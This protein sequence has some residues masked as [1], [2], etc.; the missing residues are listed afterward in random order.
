MLFAYPI[1][2]FALSALLI[3]I[4]V[5]LFQLRRYKKVV[6]SDIRFLKQITE[7]NQKQRNIKEWIILATRCLALACL[8]LAFAK[9]FIPFGKINI[10]KGS[11]KTISLF[12][13][14]S[15]SM[16]QQN[17]EGQLLEVAKN[18]AKEIASFYNDNDNFLL[19]SNDFE[20]KHQQ[21]LN[22]KDLLTLI[23]EVKISQQSKDLA[24][25]IARQ[26]QQLEGN[27]G[28]NKIAY[29]ISD[30]Q[31]NQFQ[32]S[33][34]TDSS[35]QFHLVQIKPNQNNNI[36]I[37][38]AW[39][40]QPIILPNTSTNLSVKV[41]NF[42]QLDISDV[43][44]TFKID[45]IQKGIA[46]ISCKANSSVV[47]QLQFTLNDIA[48]HQAELSVL[49]NPVVF[50]DKLLL[51][52]KAFGNQT[53][54]L[55]NANDYIQKVFTLDE[56][57]KIINQSEKAIDYSLFSNASLIIINEMST[58]SSGF[59]TEIQK[60]LT[61]GGIVLFIPS[62]Q[63]NNQAQINA[64]LQ[65]INAPLYGAKTAQR[66]SV[67]RINT[68][69]DV[70]KNVF[71]KIPE[72][73][74][75]PS[76]NTFYPLQTNSS[77]NG[78]AV[79]TLNNDAPFIFKSKYGKGYTYLLSV[80]L[81]KEWSNFTEHALFVP[82][83]LRL[84]LVNKQSNQ[85]YYYTTKPIN[86]IFDKNISQKVIYLKKDKQEMAFDLSTR[87]NR[88]SITID[89]VKQAGNYLLLNQSKTET[90]AAISFNVNRKESNLALTSINEQTTIPLLQTNELLKHQKEIDLTYNGTQLW[91]WFLLAA[92]A[93]I[94]VEVVLLKLK[95]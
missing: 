60:Y 28:L 82:F 76:V 75:W 80:P 7:Q 35:V 31:A 4:I 79:A 63:N 72:L 44:L 29:I 64:F 65:Q 1:F 71:S 73:S 34:S 83:M 15:Y 43:P 37:D 17:N 78:Y 66:V 84:P 85:L 48:Y 26:K 68:F 69:D 46:N 55:I 86:Y 58:L 94:L 77:I 74:N 32:N 9:P 38:T 54:L 49:D 91:R 95:F 39:I 62:V 5:H 45:G 41:S 53:V 70:F 2:L 23:D 27:V 88:S 89:N 36:A 87:N 12:I 42:G 19:L 3:P 51:T 90:I 52:L 14:N 59:Q 40:D 22:K 20:G 57:Y 93:F 25:I 67:S 13:D 18:K 56:N 92:I 21:I 81:Q 47:I 10:N 50:D 33:N 11:S 61:N 30:L 24:Q 8:V 16:S 6:F